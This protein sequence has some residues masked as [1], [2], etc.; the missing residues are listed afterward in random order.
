[1]LSLKDIIV[2]VS[3]NGNDFLNYCI[4]VGKSV[5]YHCKRN[6]VIPQF[7]VI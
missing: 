7:T 2:G 4:L 6:N 1:M 5:I 3:G